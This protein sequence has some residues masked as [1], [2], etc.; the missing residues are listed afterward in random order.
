MELIE[1]LVYVIGFFLIWGF[2]AFAFW[3]IDRFIIK[4]IFGRTIIN[5]EVWK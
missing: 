4:P 2:T 5:E 3:A 1:A